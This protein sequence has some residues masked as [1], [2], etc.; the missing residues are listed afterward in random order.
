MR[1]LECCWSFLSTRSILHLL[2]SWSELDKR[3]FFHAGKCV[4]E[5]EFCFALPTVFQAL[6]AF[7]KR[8]SRSETHVVHVDHACECCCEFSIGHAWDTLVL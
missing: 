5:L 1:Q 7:A 3:A 8:S 4:S 2:Q 6:A